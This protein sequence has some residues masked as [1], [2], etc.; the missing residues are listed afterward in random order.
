MTIYDKK[1]SFYPPKINERFQQPKNV[2][3]LTDADAVG[4]G[5]SFVCGA[6]VRFYL[7]IEV[8]SKEITG[9]KFKSNGC[10][11]TIAAADVLTEIIIGTRLIE[12]HGLDK[13][14]LNSQIET[15]LGEFPAERKHCLQICL[16]ALQNS[17]TDFRARQ[18]E[19]FSGEKA[20]ICTCFGVSED[21]IET[22]I[23]KNLLATVEEVTEIC[24]AGGGCGSCQPLIQDILDVLHDE[25]YAIIEN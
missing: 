4:A 19:E 16:D 20:L 10:G 11:F 2:G 18:I 3:V 24:R 17:F 25:N 21:T 12:L 1:V 14:L 15:Y 8:R 5:A 22:V 13:K 9:A 23:K 6:F 7:N